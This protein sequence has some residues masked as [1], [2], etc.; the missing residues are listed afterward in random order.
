MTSLTGCQIFSDPRLTVN[1]RDDEA[2]VCSTDLGDLYG[3][4]CLTDAEC[5]PGWSCNPIRLV[6]PA[7]VV[8]E[9]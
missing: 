3:G 1:R 7:T 6:R 2:A 9:R 5:R 8:T 4:V